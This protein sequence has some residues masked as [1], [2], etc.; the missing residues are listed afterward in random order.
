MQERVQDM[1][2]RIRNTWTSIQPREQG[3]CEE[4][5]S[6]TTEEKFRTSQT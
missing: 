4:G 3:A 2:E 6:K 5:G 1:R